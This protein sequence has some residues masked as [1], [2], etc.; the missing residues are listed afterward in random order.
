MLVLE[1]RL[2]EAF[3]EH[4]IQGSR[5]QGCQETRRL[6]RRIPTVGVKKG[7]DVEAFQYRVGVPD[8]L[9]AP[10][11]LT[12]LVAQHG[13]WQ[14]DLCWVI[15]QSVLEGVTSEAPSMT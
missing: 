7:V 10:T 4:R 3:G 9:A 11:P 13:E 1:R 8:L 14:I 2:A 5:D 6:L 15:P 12:W